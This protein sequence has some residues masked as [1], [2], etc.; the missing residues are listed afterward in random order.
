MVS[1]LYRAKRKDN[2]EWI[3]GYYA[4]AKDYLS[5]EDI[6]VIFPVDVTRFPHGEFSDHEEIIPETLGR[7]IGHA[8]YDGYHEVERMFQNDIVAVWG[9]RDDVEHAEPRDIALVTDEHSM[10]IAGGGRW[11]PQDTTRIRIRGN[12][13][14]NPELLHG[15]DMNH[16]INGLHEYPGSPEEYLRRHQF[17]TD[18]YGIHGAQACCYM[19]NFENDYICHQYN[20]GCKRIDVCRKIRDDEES[21][22][23]TTK[24][25][26]WVP[27]KIY[28]DEAVCSNCGELRPDENTDV[29]PDCGAVMDGEET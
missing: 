4:K 19:C 23:D 29:C 27:L 21:K 12:A 25:A 26:I 5:D 3:E 6:H 8:C 2:G 22:K 17:L 14:D 9:R 20:G 18:K 1:I 13:Y 28:P 7:L 11:F 16:F 15:H 24:H 10:T